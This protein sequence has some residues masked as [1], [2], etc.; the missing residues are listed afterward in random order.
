MYKLST[1]YSILGICGIFLATPNLGYPMF[2]YP[3]FGVSEFTDIM[4]I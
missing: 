4:A 2:G 1:L 3:K